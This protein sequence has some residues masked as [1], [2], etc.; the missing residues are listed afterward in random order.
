MDK[1]EIGKRLRE[2]RGVLRTREV[3]S[4]AGVTVSA[5]NMY[6]HGKRVPRDS[7][8]VRIAKMFGKSVASIFY[9]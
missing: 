6:E 7:V 4:K 2:L 9:T 1:I 5:W 3:A 8:K